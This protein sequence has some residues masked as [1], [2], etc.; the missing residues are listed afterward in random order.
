MMTEV[1]FLLDTLFLSCEGEDIG[2]AAVREV[3][4]ETNVTSEFQFLIS[5]RHTH[6]GMFKCSDIYFVV[7]LKP[8][9]KEINK[10]NREIAACEWMKVL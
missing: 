6:N 7:G 9:S 10:C 4:E 3:F 8:V 2:D 5:L 1:S